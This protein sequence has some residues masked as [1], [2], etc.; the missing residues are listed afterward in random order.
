MNKCTFRR[1]NKIFSWFDRNNYVS[2][3]TRG[4]RTITRKIFAKNSRQ[5]LIPV[6]G[7]VLRTRIKDLYYDSIVF[8]NT[9]LVSK[10]LS[11]LVIML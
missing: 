8:H 11:S 1:L 4:P 7:P 3:G 5:G 9:G 6:L 10:K 2:R